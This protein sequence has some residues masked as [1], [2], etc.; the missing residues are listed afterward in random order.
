MKQSMQV[1]TSRN[2]GVWYTP[3]WYL[4][5]VRSTLGGINLDPAS[6]EKAQHEIVKA[7]HYFTAEQDGLKQTWNYDTVF[8][9]PP[10]SDEN[11]KPVTPKWAKK[12]LDE[13]KNYKLLIALVNANFGYDWFTNLVRAD[14][15]Q[16][17]IVHYDRMSF[18]NP[19]TMKA[20]GKSKK[21]QATLL[22]APTKALYFN[23]IVE[24]L[25]SFLSVF[26]NLGFLLK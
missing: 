2:T 9:N 23:D 4:D 15:V 12:M 13:S 3:N 1:L 16:S 11:G 21:A 10:Y 18:I 6:D 8:V 17:V 26:T 19:Q 22:I 25:L 14:E 24:C 5:M 20:G 7:D